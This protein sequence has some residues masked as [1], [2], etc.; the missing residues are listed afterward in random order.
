[1]KLRIAYIMSIIVLAIMCLSS[2]FLTIRT[3]LSLD[4]MVL[5]LLVIYIL[6]Y[7]N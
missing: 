6:N 4:I 5:G 3:S 7:E 2:L 1:M